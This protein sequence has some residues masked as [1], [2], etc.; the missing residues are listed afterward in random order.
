MSGADR[1]SA[2]STGHASPLT[3]SGGALLVGGRAPY[4]A[5]LGLLAAPAVGVNVWERLW[6]R[7]QGVN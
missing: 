3:T 1:D 5:T 7:R 4:L 2:R 6:I